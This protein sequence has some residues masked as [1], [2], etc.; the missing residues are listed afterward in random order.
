MP[1][2]DLELAEFGPSAASAACPPDRGLVDEAI[3]EMSADGIHFTAYGCLVVWHGQQFG[4]YR[5]F[6]E[7]RALHD[8]LAP[9]IP[10]LR[11]PLW[12]WPPTSWNLTSRPDV[13]EKRANGLSLYLSNVVDACKH[14][15]EL[16]LPLQRFLAQDEEEEAHEPR[17]TSSSFNRLSRSPQSTEDFDNTDPEVVLQTMQ[18]HVAALVQLHPMLRDA[19]AQSRERAGRTSD[20]DHEPY[21]D[22]ES[23]DTL[24]E[25]IAPEL[26]RLENL[27]SSLSVHLIT[28]RMSP[29]QAPPGRLEGQ[30]GNS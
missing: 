19:L 20:A 18:Q 9:I 1:L 6:A 15:D 13:I 12:P 24:C 14:L 27:C 4:V 22:L 10:G 8:C 29:Q 26:S 11:F 3:T 5:R 25:R 7:F 16:P 17:T 2:P 23:A 28:D 21:E 30:D